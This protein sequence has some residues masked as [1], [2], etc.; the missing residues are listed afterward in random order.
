MSQSLDDEKLSGNGAGQGTGGDEDDLEDVETAASAPDESDDAEAP[1][2]LDAEAVGD[3]QPVAG[4]DAGDAEDDDHDHEVH[5]ADAVR[6]SKPKAALPSKQL[7]LDPQA[8]DGLIR[9]LQARILELDATLAHATEVAAKDSFYSRW[10][11]VVGELRTQALK[12]LEELQ[13]S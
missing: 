6:E 2:E 1:A 3:A 13:R 11:N 9:C 5:P 10:P 7:P 8:R 4:G 12:R